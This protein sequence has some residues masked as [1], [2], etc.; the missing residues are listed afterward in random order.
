M[1]QIGLIDLVQNSGYLGPQEGKQGL[2]M[3]L[4]N[5]LL[6]RME[7]YMSFPPSAKML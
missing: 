6:L 3:K 7:W 2:K 1:L 4:Y 5:V